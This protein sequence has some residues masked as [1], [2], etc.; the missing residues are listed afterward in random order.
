MSLEK[1]NEYVYEFYDLDLVFDDASKT[2][3]ILELILSKN[4][5]F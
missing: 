5:E 3:E 2:G 1:D 4:K